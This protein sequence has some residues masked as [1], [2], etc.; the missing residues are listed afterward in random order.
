MAEKE[1]RH[2]AAQR[3][4]E[5][6]CFESACMKRPENILEG[7]LPVLTFV[8][9]ALG[10]LDRGSTAAEKTPMQAGMPRL[11]P[12]GRVLGGRYRVIR[13]IGSG[14]MGSVYEAVQ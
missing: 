4:F 11:D 6:A 3:L 5:W 10:P 1:A 12:V 7:A 8:A 13:T 9:W 14:G 2:A